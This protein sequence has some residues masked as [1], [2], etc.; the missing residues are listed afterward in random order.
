MTSSTIPD[1]HE[2][3][4]KSPLALVCHDAGAANL[5]VS[6]MKNWQGVVI[7]FMQGPA[8]KIWDEHFPQIKNAS[9]LATAITFASVV[10]T[11]TSWASDLEHIAR[12]E[13][14]RQKKQNVAVLDHWVNYSS[15]FEWSGTIKLP[16][17]IIVFDEFAREIATNIFRPIPIVTLKNF[18]EENKVHLIN[19]LPKG[20]KN[21][22]LY[23][24]EP[25]RDKWGKD[26]DG[27]FQAIDYFFDMFDRIG[28]D[29]DS[30]IIFRPHPS[31]CINKYDQYLL[32]FSQY[33]IKIDAISP[34]EIAIAESES[35]V[36]CQSYA[37]VIA[38]KAGRKVI[39]VLP[40]NAP[41]CN[42][43]HPGIIRLKELDR[44]SYE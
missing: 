14:S 19:D 21:T 8:K 16:D 30:K 33:N 20:R 35:V 23:L 12:I 6:W 41:N 13:A 10:V 43:P 25:A 18:Y 31:E 36:G 28:F 11:G 22:I 1:L 5:I 3:K 9:D 39:S 40:K 27:E 32:R 24:L 26:L 7:P 2:I 4:L 37:M 17:Q 15:R 42:L 29:L 38:L 44:I 34:L